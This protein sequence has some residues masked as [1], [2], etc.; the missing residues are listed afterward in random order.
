MCSLKKDE[1]LYFI[2]RGLLY[3]TPAFIVPAQEFYPWYVAPYKLIVPM[4]KTILFNFYNI[5]RLLVK[6][7]LAWILSDLKNHRI[8]I[9]LRLVTDLQTHKQAF[10]NFV[11]KNR[12]FEASNFL[13]WR[14][15]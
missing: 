8:T 11:H 10:S 5:A 7:T 15:Y 1:H 6:A 13:I 9:L 14:F 4:L 12:D 2:T 3:H